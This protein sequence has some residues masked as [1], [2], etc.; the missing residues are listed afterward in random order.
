MNEVT[1]LTHADDEG[2]ARM[3]DV[4]NKDTTLRSAKATGTIGM[5]ASTL[6]A[7]RTNSLKKGDVLSVARIAGI[8]AAK[9][10]SSLIP[11]CHPVALTNISIDFNLD[12]SIPGVRVAAEAR[13]LD[14]TGIEMEALTAVTVAL[15]TIY[16]MAKA[17]DRGMTIGAIELLEKTG[18]ASGDWT[19]S[20]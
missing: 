16:D 4:S 20:G 5:A 2:R 14:R 9:Q 8:M 11:L 3:V 7:I 15:L 18:G 6:D 13:T 12:E 10:T 19:R 1:T 17:I